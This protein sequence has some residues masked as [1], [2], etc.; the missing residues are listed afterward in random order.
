MATH[1]RSTA[2]SE[3]P[4]DPRERILAI[5][6]V[7]LYRD[8]IQQ[9][10]IEAIA[11]AAGVSRRQF[12][13]NFATKEQLVVAYI[14]DRHDRD[15]RL[16]GAA[17]ETDISHHMVFNMVLSEIIADVNTPGFRG[18]AFLNAIVECPELEGVQRAIAEHRE[19]Y[20]AQATELL[21]AAGHQRPADAAVTLMAAR[22]EAMD[23]KYGDDATAATAG[24]RR[25]MDQVLCDLSSSEGG[26]FD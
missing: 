4:L 14:N 12:S 18:C 10:S 24:L 3:P 20:L 19:W 8:G 17:A 7:V 1:A 13:K 22:D 5:A 23:S 9:T 2:A 16:L 11:T 15:A 21:R 26:T 6:D 25:A